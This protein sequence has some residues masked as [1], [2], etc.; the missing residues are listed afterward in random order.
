MHHSRW[1]KYGNYA[2]E[3]MYE[4]ER[5]SPCTMD[6]AVG[7]ELGPRE[8]DSHALLDCRPLIALGDEDDWDAGMVIPARSGAGWR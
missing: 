8:L 2:D 6:C 7:V 5:D 3:R 4:V 1:F